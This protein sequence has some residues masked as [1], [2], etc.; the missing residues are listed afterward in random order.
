MNNHWKILSFTVSHHSPCKDCI[1][2]LIH[3]LKRKK[4]SQ[5][6]FILQILPCHLELSD[7]FPF[8]FPTRLFLRQQ[9]PQNLGISLPNVVT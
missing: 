3:M 6:V 5:R 7:N 2:N 4:H 1:N 8:P 9:K